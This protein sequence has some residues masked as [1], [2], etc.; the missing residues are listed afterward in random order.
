MAPLTS[1]VDAMMTRTPPGPTARNFAIAGAL[2]LA[3]AA[4]LGAAMDAARPSAAASPRA[5]G[6]S[7]VDTFTLLRWGQGALDWTLPD[8][9]GDRHARTPQPRA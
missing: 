5:V 8:E 6:V 7:L 3:A 4:S 9:K 1:P 2:V